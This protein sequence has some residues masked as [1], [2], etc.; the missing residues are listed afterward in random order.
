MNAVLQLFPGIVERYACWVCFFVCLCV[1]VCVC[2]SCVRVIFSVFPFASSLPHP[3][4]LITSY[5]S[6]VYF[7]CVRLQFDC[8]TYC[9]RV[10]ARLTDIPHELFPTEL[11]EVT[12]CPYLHKRSLCKSVQ[13]SEQLDGIM[14][15]HSA[16]SGDPEAIARL[17]ALQLVGRSVS[18]Q[19]PRLNKMFVKAAS[20]LETASMSRGALQLSAA[21]QHQASQ[22][23]RELIGGLAHSILTNVF[24]ASGTRIGDC[25]ANY[26][27][28]QDEFGYM[29]NIARRCPAVLQNGGSKGCHQWEVFMGQPGGAMRGRGRVLPGAQPGGDRNCKSAVPVRNVVNGPGRQLR[30]QYTHMARRYHG[31][32]LR[33]GFSALK[34]ATTN[35]TSATNSQLITMAGL[36]AL[37]QVAPPGTVI[38]HVREPGPAGS[39]HDYILVNAHGAHDAHNGHAF[40]VDFW[41]GL[42]GGS[43]HLIHDI[44]YNYGTHAHGFKDP[45]HQP[46]VRRH[47]PTRAEV[48]KYVRAGVFRGDPVPAMSS[49]SSSSMGIQETRAAFAK[50]AER[51][52]QQRIALRT[53][54]DDEATPKSKEEADDDAEEKANKAPVST[55]V[56]KEN[57]RRSWRKEAWQRRYKLA[58]KIQ[59]LPAASLS[60]AEGSSSARQQ[61]G[62]VGADGHV[63]DITSLS[64]PSSSSS[65][66]LLQLS[67]DIAL[68]KEAEAAWEAHV[69]TQKHLVDVVLR[70]YL[71]EKYHFD[72]R[73]RVKAMQALARERAPFLLN[74]HE[75]LHLSAN[76]EFGRMKAMH[77]ASMF[78][79][80]PFINS[81]F[82][83]ASDRDQVDMME[84]AA[85]ASSLVDVSNPD[86]ASQA[87]AASSSLVEAAAL[88]REIE[89]LTHLQTRLADVGSRVVHIRQGTLANGGKV[90]DAEAEA[91]LIESSSSSKSTSTA[92]SSTGTSTA[93]AAGTTTTS[94]TTTS[95]LSLSTDP[96][97]AELERYAHSELDLN[98]PV[99]A[100]ASAKAVQLTSDVERISRATR[101]R[102]S[103]AELQADTDKRIAEAER[104]YALFLEGERAAG[105][106]AEQEAVDRP[107]TLASLKEALVAFSATAHPDDLKDLQNII[108]MEEQ[109]Q[110]MIREE[111][112]AHKAKVAELRERSAERSALDARSNV[113]AR[114]NALERKADAERVAE[115]EAKKWLAQE[116]ARLAA[117][118]LL[119]R[120][121]ARQA[122]E[123]VNTYL[124][125]AR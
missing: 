15:L 42:A 61:Q 123:S 27:Y 88:V 119:E 93:A 4:P 28:P 20:F 66:S 48:F 56:N 122:E 51:D 38:T 86:S 98:A 29:L 101:E 95:A 22:A 105:R 37:V 108:Q 50:Y 81:G 100:D 85:L 65:S 80:K 59:G 8:E 72:D 10:D 26:P 12:I 30:D 71:N 84:A 99:E 2:E 73:S 54:G 124:G 102:M 111:V 103:L 31:T 13:D 35:T 113:I 79:E 87:G 67:A 39:Y 60:F 53:K 77:S 58:M 1:C 75:L 89:D 70:N 36:Y 19:L 21:A 63:T 17:E 47:D 49:V 44:P 110:E 25:D 117:A 57:E 6:I 118:F 109:A 83:S 82:G 33:V 11:C 114:M 121:S 96:I 78:L 45:Q 64:S 112:E 92:P 62:V 90:V 76:S 43:K 120:D 24:I 16:Y 18:R 7:K 23:S 41:M 125:M 34:L 40:I 115:E 68:E 3:F 9:R 14:D 46:V 91:N 107:V 52:T 104:K 55:R 5:P 69:R 106:L 97:L 32:Q 74:D 94:N 116:K